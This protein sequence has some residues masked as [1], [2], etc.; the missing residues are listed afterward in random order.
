MINFIIGL[1]IGT[2]AGYVAASLCVISKISDNYPDDPNERES[3]GDD[4][5]I[6]GGDA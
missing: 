4:R 6:T 2:V 1:I 5:N 3:S